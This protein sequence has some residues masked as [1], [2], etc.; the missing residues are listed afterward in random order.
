MFY[1]LTTNEDNLRD[2]NP[3]ITYYYNPC[4]S[5]NISDGCDN[6]LVRLIIIICDTYKTCNPNTVDKQLTWND[7]II[8]T[9]MK[10]R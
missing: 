1:R 9:K 2:G 3:N 5:F 4:N 7:T 10:P 8:I 6:V